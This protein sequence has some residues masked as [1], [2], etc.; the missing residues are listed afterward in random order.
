MRLGVILGGDC[1][2]W[3]SPAPTDKRITNADAEIGVLRDLPLHSGI[4]AWDAEGTVEI[5]AVD[6]HV[7]DG[8]RRS[9]LSNFEDVGSR[10]GST[11][12]AKVV[13]HVAVCKLIHT[14][15]EK[16]IE[17]GVKNLVKCEGGR[18]GG[19]VDLPYRDR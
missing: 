6:P 17:T 14:A 18:F 12:T 11:D 13:F 1:P 2:K 8:L 5:C 3:R 9:D 7:P 16:T 15:A 19:F 10:S 4:Q